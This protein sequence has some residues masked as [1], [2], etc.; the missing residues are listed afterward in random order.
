M[1]VNVRV[2]ADI[3]DEVRAELV[4]IISEAVR[5]AANHGG[6]RHVRVDLAG[7]PLAVRVIDD[8]N[9]FR[10]GANSGL[11]VAGYGLIAMRE[12]A[13]QV[14]G[15]VQPGIR[16]RCGYSRPGGAAIDQVRVLVADDHAPTREDIAT[17]LGQDGGFDVIA[18]AEDAPG[19]VDAALREQPDLALL[20]VNM[21][22]SGLAAAWEI[23]A[24]LPATRVVMLTI[25][26]DDSHVFAA[27]RAGAAGYLLKDTE[28]E[29]LP[30]RAA[31]R[32]GRRGGAAGDAGH[33]AWSRSS[34]TARRAGAR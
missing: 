23:T 4:R 1:Q 34:A 5:N 9:G 16:P 25:S 26:R 10:D 24:R 31:R 13:E 28:T 27:L 19:A 30:Q 2:V 29:R 32:D 11:G 20:D 15:T 33:A 14:G 3:T 12:R 7:S 17:A 22:G 8:G 21:P 18:T 6:A